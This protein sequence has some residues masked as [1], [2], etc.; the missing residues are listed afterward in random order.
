MIEIEIERESRV[1]VRVRE[2]VCERSIY[3]YMDAVSV[4]MVEY[5][6]RI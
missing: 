5:I 3:I 1:P 6:I 4:V 2:R